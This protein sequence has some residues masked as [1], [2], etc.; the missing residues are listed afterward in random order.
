MAPFFRFSAT[1]S[2]KLPISVLVEL[3]NKVPT[4]MYAFP[5]YVPL[6]V[7]STSLYVFEGIAPISSD[8]TNQASAF[9]LFN[10]RSSECFREKRHRINT[11]PPSR[12]QIHPDGHLIHV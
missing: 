12:A 6:N 2:K 4:M 7:M 8:A 3:E 1:D 10:E 11:D 9:L 5:G